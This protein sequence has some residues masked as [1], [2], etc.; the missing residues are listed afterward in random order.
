M[1]IDTK[2]FYPSDS[3]IVNHDD[4]LFLLHTHYYRDIDTLF[5]IYI[6]KTTGTS[7]LEKH[8]N[9]EVPVFIARKTPKYPQE[10]IKRDSCDRYMVPYSRKNKA[11]RELLFEGKRVYFKD[12]W[13]NEMQKILMPDIPYKAEYL[14]PGVFMLDVPI[15]QW[16]FI[17]KSKTQY[18]FNDKD[19][20]VES[21]IT[22]PDIH[23]ASFD[24]ETSKDENGEWYIN[25][26]TFVDEFTKEAYIDFPIF[27]DGRYKRQDFLIANKEKFKTDLKAKFHEVVEH[28]ELKANAK[29]IKLVKDTC[30][31][32]IDNLTI[33]VRD[34]K[35]E[36]TF[37]RETTET[38][39]TKHKPHILMA[40][41]TPYDIGTFQERIEKLGLPL[42]T[43]NERGIG[44]DNI[45]PPYASDNNKDR[46][47][48]TKL[49]GDQFNPTE[50]KVYLN[51]I[52][53]TLISDFQTCFYSLR[54]GSNYSTFNL[55][56]TANRIVGFGKL[57]YSHICNNILYLPYEDFYTHAMYALIDSILLIICNKIG[58]EFYKKLIYVQLSKTNIE[59]T[60]SPNIAVIRS[61]QT[62]VGVMSSMIPGN[63]INKVL[64]SM[65]MEE[66]VKI[67][68]L[69][70]IDYTKQKYTLSQGVSF[71]GGLVADPLL[72]KIVSDVL[73]AY[74]ILKDEA[75]ITTFMKFISV[76]Y[77]D[78][79]SH[80]PFQMYTR[81]LSRSTLVGV[82]NQIIRKS[83][84]EPIK[85]VGFLKG[86]KFKNKV[87][88]LGNIN[89]AMINRDIIS[90]G[91]ITSGLPS[92]DEL[93]KEFMHFDTEP[94]TEVIKPK[95]YERVIDKPTLTAY[96][97]V[98]SI[99]TSINRLRI[100]AQEEKYMPKDAKYFF[101]NNGAMTYNNSCLVEYDYKNDM[102]TKEMLDGIEFD[103]NEYNL[104]YYGTIVKDKLIFSSDNYKVPKNKPFDLSDK[105]FYPIDEDELLKLA[106]AEVYPTTLNLRDNIKIR[107]VNRAF[108]FPFK[109]WVK[110]ILLARDSKG[111]PKKEPE[112]STPVYR[113]E[114]LE[115]T[116]KIQFQ[117]SI[118]HKE[119]IHLYINIYMQIKN[120]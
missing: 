87:K 43:M 88:S 51:N 45:R 10:Y 102:F 74:P 110:Q 66:V 115:E 26:N 117:Y 58:S 60:P 86:A 35:D 42:G 81:N 54:R 29:T 9:P 2:P 49:K 8:E 3:T 77:L 93:I 100:D 19:K 104:S 99:L 114:K 92:L 46:F 48:K 107:M 96:S 85:Y 47:D 63:N 27:E 20:V 75:H 91:N 18:H 72:K 32:F 106:E 70:N 55:E 38:M 80:Y 64:S 105:K 109:N 69:L 25:M 120:I 61:Y 65:K 90:Y 118:Y 56:D 24:I 94:I 5:N 68:K 79:K 71:G 11:T 44:Y 59:E 101:L 6:N 113:Y 97:T 4:N 28:L 62:D 73:E 67:S 17:E 22:I 1:N 78:L 40:F 14:H 30:N 82:I 36:A 7:V 53:H 21:D 41:N 34:F 52:S 89:V 50:R 15:E 13:G 31:E 119:L 39:F 98:K 37:I 112:I 33:H 76:L 108:Y 95:V 12:E 57:D 83:D 84:G 116:T 16:T 103:D 23:Y 111:L